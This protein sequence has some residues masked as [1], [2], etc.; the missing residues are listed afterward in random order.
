MSLQK[1]PL[2]FVLV[3]LRF[4]QF[5][6]WLFLNHPLFQKNSYLKISF[7]N[8]FL[9]RYHQMEITDAFPENLDQMQVQIFSDQTT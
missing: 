6:L 3:K 7:I 2:L 4:G 9:V 5:L 1:S 8:K